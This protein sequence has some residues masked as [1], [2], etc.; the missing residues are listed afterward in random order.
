MKR[1]EK[2]PGKINASLVEDGK[3]IGGGRK[4]RACGPRH[5]LAGVKVDA[6]SDEPDDVKA[7]PA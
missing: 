5:V 3:N 4:H 7:F 1:V 6:E 2:P